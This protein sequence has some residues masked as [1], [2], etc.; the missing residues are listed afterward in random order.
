MFWCLASFHRDWRLK[1]AYIKYKKKKKVATPN[2]S[3]KY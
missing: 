1:D 3:L 2:F